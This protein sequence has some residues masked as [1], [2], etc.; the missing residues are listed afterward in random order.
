MATE[1]P[2]ETLEAGR[3][4]LLRRAKGALFEALL[5]GATLVGVL[6]LLALFALIGLDA[7]GLSEASPSWYLGYFGV[8]VAPV[9]LYTLYVR[10]RPAVAAVNARAFGVTFGTL[11]LGLVVYAVAEALEPTDVAVYFIGMFGPPAAV[12]GYARWRGE[13]RL[14][15]PAVPLSILVG[16]LAVA[17]VHGPLSSRIESLVDWTVYLGV[18]TL[19]VAGVLG[20]VAGCR[21]RARYGLAVAA[22]VATSGLAAAQVGAVAGVD[23][24]LALVAATGVA[25]PVGGQL[26]GGATDWDRETVFGL[27]GAVFGLIVYTAAETFGQADVVVYGV[28]VLGPVVAILGYARR[29][30]DPGPEVRTVRSVPVELV[31]L[32]LL[33]VPVGVATVVGVYG[34][35]SAALEPLLDWLLYL[36]FVTVPA[37]GV[38]GA[39][40]ARRWT[41]R[42]GLAAAGT[43]AVSGV[44]AAQV[45]PVVGVD[46]ALALVLV[47]VFLV[48]VGVLVADTLGSDTDG[49]VG[50]VGPLVLVGGIALGATVESQFGLAGPDTWLR[51]TLLLESWSGF[52]PEQAGIYPP[53]VGSIITVGLMTFLAF[54]VGVGAAIYLEEYAPESGPWATLATAL[55]INISN[56]AGVPSVVYGLLGLALFQQALGLYP[57]L[58]I[59]GSV[60]LGLLILPIVIVA[61]QEA[62]RSVPDEFREASYALGAS[63]WQTVRSVVLPE[64]FPGILTGTI[65]AVGRAIGETAPL[66]MLSFATTTFTAPD[67]LL[68]DGAALPLQIFAARASNIPEYRTGVVAAAAI[69]LLTL[70]L[71]L[72]ATAILLRN[73]YQREDKG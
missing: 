23:P 38:L 15:G 34:P 36:V 12:V 67:G 52:R 40:V 21:M 27:A 33:W 70:M 29:Y 19:P 66:V 14:A 68:S 7:L 5:V 18:V 55:D 54:P 39:V 63:R 60:T 9:G 17:G 20:A 59:A 13:S 30:G 1:T 22:L 25:A 47:S 4:Q 56:L 50:L 61:S 31:G 73:R 65:L 42:Y 8:L 49:R 57:G 62:L 28:F 16:L 3:G 37:A 44:A 41:T 51:P 58:V 46:P 10:R 2:G 43:V 53:L 72:N 11:A 69:V 45:G 64:A 71:L 35:V 32:A 26:V 48:P 24:G 6:A